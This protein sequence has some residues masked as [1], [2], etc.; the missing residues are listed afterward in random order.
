MNDI[1]PGVERWIADHVDGSSPPLKFDRIAGGYSNRTY[2]V[3]DADG[4]RSVLR[5][6]PAHAVPSG[7]HDVAREHRILEA[8]WPTA[9]PTPRPLGLCMDGS[10]SPVPF[11]LMSFAEGRVVAGVHEVEA[12][13][14]TAAA[15][16]SVGEHVIDTLADLHLVDVDAI[17]L[18]ELA[19]RDCYVER[20]LARMGRIW[21]QTR[22]REL[23]LVEQVRSR[24][25]AARPPQRHTGLVHA[26]F[27]LG[28]LVVASSGAVNAILDWEL[29]TVGDVLADVAFLLNNWEQ[30]EDDH[31]PVWMKRPPTL[32]G[33]FPSRR[34]IIDR[35]AERTRFELGALAYHR[36][37]AYWRPAVIA[38]GIKHRYELRRARV[39]GGNDSK[40]EAMD[41]AYLDRRV[42]DAAAL[43]DHHLRLI[44][45]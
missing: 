35:Y 28:N 20:Q 18:G 39:G 22:T 2:L 26:D 44:G 41:P 7:A 12:H 27:R 32:A 11:Y 9:V 34:E 16:R 38:E 10:V 33:G 1:G 8:L 23:P 25:A 45:A 24:L 13:L 14:P 6:P 29:C 19:R 43:A 42:Q 5:C 3:I 30:P 4:Q 31:P 37:L 40:D 36:A 15:R 21:D 17:G